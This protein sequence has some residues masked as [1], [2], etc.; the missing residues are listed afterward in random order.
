MGRTVVRYA[1]GL[2]LLVGFGAIALQ[3]GE[4]EALKHRAINTGGGGVAPGAAGSAVIT[5]AGGAVTA[6]AAGADALGV[7]GTNGA[8]GLAGADGAAGST[9]AAGVAGTAGAGGSGSGTAGTGAAGTGVAGAGAAGVSGAGGAGGSGGGALGTAGVGG[10]GGAAGAAGTV[11]GSGGGKGGAGGAGGA[12][13]SADAGVPIN[14]CD[15]ANWKATASITG[16]DGAGPVGGIDGNLTTRWGNNRGQD[17]TDWYQ[18]D[19]GG[20]VKLKGLKLDNTQ[21]YPDDYPGGYAVSGS[22]DGVT[23]DANPFVTG[24]GTTGTTIITFAERTVRA[25]KIKQTGTARS[26]NWWQIGEL[27]PTCSL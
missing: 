25:V 7:A 20:Q 4:P 5:G 14:Y 15:H 13:P 6:G 9:G 21:T 18:V 3:C 16:G 24:N 2:V 10:S 23:F 11:G 17:G 19:F 1:R 8:S 22:T 12:S 27:L 26:T